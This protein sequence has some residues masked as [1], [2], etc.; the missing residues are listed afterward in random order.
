M[1]LF[2]EQTE[3]SMKVSEEVREFLIES[4]ENLRVLDCELL[5]LEK[6]PSDEEL[7]ASVFRTMHSIKGTCGFFGF[8]TLR[9]VTHAAEK[10]L[11]QVREKRRSLTPDLISLI[12][13]TAAVVKLVLVNI[14]ARG[15]EGEDVYQGLRRQLDNA[16]NS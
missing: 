11:G 14:E 13:Q 9:S 5:E 2:E 16:D 1:P 12:L 4:N 10:A 6:G 15:E 7:I 8:E 3:V